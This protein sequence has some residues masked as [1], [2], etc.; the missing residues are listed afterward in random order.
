MP[1]ATQADLIQRFG[2][3]ELIQLTDRAQIGQVDRATV[4][5]A[6]GDADAAIEGYLAGRYAV[7]VS[8]IPALLRRMACDIARFFLYGNAAPEP[9]RQA[10]E[11]ALRVLK[12]LADGRAVLVGA[13][14]A[15]LG[16]VPA[17]S[18]GTV[19]VDA[20]LRGLDRASL[21]DYLG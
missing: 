12:D 14:P 11:D 9:V 15:A 8:P 17:A 20:P 10:Y 2:D 4:T 13:V 19:R 5:A 3:E 1:Y 21:G 16:A 18:P 7:P 6:L